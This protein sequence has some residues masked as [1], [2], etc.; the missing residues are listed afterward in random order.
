MNYYDTLN[1]NDF[2]LD[3]WKQIVLGYAEEIDI[4]KYAYPYFSTNQMK[5]IRDG[6][7][8][9]VNVDVYAK[10]EYNH[11]QMKVI[12]EG[13]LTI[14]FDGENFERLNVS[15]YAKPYFSEEQMLV[16]FDGLKKKIKAEFY[17]DPKY[18][19]E[20]MLEIFKGLRNKIDVTE[21]LD[22]SLSPSQMR[23]IRLAIEQGFDYHYFKEPNIRQNLHEPIF[24]ALID[25]SDVDY[26]LSLTK[27][28]IRFELFNEIYREDSRVKTLN[29]DIAKLDNVRLGEIRLCFRDKLPN[30]IIEEM[31][32]NDYPIYLFRQYR[33]AYND[34]L[35]VEKMMANKSTYLSV[36]EKREEKSKKNQVSEKDIDF[37][38][39]NEEQAKEIRIGLKKGVDVRHYAKP[40]YSAR[41]MMNLRGVIL[42]PI[43]TQK[44]KET[45]LNHK[46]LDYDIYK[47]RREMRAKSG[48]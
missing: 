28:P 4:S 31:V 8:Q 5:E 33:Y 47:M 13:L 23:Y 40:E 1:K 9:K 35:D 12:K 42:D 45:L 37:S 36:L 10:K 7:L 46:G 43:L 20:Q 19:Y 29:A 14:D 30:H 11:H 16:I 41:R 17:A 15:L 24:K 44:Q 27:D 3:Q 26:F 48:N 2:T 22:E 32:N 38:L 34:K 39:F 21:L 6:L 18:S 25:K